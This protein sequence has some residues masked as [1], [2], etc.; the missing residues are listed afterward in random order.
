MPTSSGA[1]GLCGRAV[2][3][4][5]LEE[6]ERLQRASE[7]QAA[8]EQRKL[9]EAARREAE[10]QRRIAELE[11]N[12]AQHAAAAAT[13]NSREEHPADHVV[14]GVAAEDVGA[15]LRRANLGARPDDLQRWVTA[16]R[17][18]LA[19]A[20]STSHS[21]KAPTFTST[22]SPTFRSGAGSELARLRAALVQGGAATL[23]AALS[24]IVHAAAGRRG[25][26]IKLRKA[27]HS[28]CHG[29]PGAA[30]AADRHPV[31]RSMSGVTFAFSTH[32]SG[33]AERELEPAQFG[34]LRLGRAS[35]GSSID[36][37]TSSTGAV[38]VY[39][40]SEPEP[41]LG[42]RSPGD[43]DI[44]TFEAW[45]QQAPAAP[46]EHGMMLCR[47]VQCTVAPRP[48]V[49]PVSLLRELGASGVELLLE[50]WKQKW[51]QQEGSV[52]PTGVRLKVEKKLRQLQTTS[53]TAATSHTHAAALESQSGVQILSKEHIVSPLG[54]L[55][56]KGAM[57]KVHAAT[58]RLSLTPGQQQ[59]PRRGAHHQPVVEVE[60]AV[61]LLAP[62]HAT[63]QRGEQFSTELQALCA[64][65]GEHHCPSLVR[66]WGVVPQLDGC[67]ALVMQRMLEGSL[68]D[69][70]RCCRPAAGGAAGL[71][72]AGLAP[73][74]AL[75]YGLQL[76]E[77]LVALHALGIAI[78]GLKT[79]NC[80]LAGDGTRVLI[81]DFGAC[82]RACEHVW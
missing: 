14:G 73:A 17:S 24:H 71:A 46:P 45:W 30:A 66:V 37:G 59:Q 42:L 40:Q 69:L 77:A 15:W 11:A 28:L 32:N 35:V 81:N 22:S 64:Q 58:L 78:E 16:V 9:A 6:F 21:G 3:Q 56:G 27:L 20:P 51:Q 34:A 65:L 1:E 36:G 4:V 61:K 44:T 76:C 75:H 25:H 62:G 50:A 53:S 68:L 72:P 33:S 49:E 57:G 79:A 29:G 13:R 52:V 67:V 39:E 43:H 47:L 7:T 41:E 80:L 12:Q 48:S 31:T 70:L 5:A 63:H 74:T 10:M 2:C 38:G 8:S 54:A 82:P 23:D 60:V 19:L 55:L 18:W 26:E